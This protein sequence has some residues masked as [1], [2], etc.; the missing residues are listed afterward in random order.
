MG[1]RPHVDSDQKESQSSN[2]CGILNSDEPPGRGGGVGS[3]VGEPRQN[4][5]QFVY[6]HITDPDS[7]IISHFYQIEVK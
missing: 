4:P 6:L 7:L 1:N 3:A 2:F 5:I